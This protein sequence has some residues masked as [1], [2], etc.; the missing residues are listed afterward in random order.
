MPPKAKTSRDTILK[1]ALDLTREQGEGAL[2]ARAIAD[3]IGCSTQPIF[4]NYASMAELRSDVTRAAI[5]CYHNMVE[6]EMRDHP[7][8]PYK[9]SGLAYI[10][11]AKEERELFKLLF[12]RERTPA[13]YIDD[14]KSFTDRIVTLVS[15]KTGFTPEE[16][17]RLHLELW[18]FVHGIASMI[19]TAYLDWDWDNISQMLSDAYL[20][21][22][23]HHKEKHAASESETAE[24]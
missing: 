21:L 10:R 4:S 11:F 2:N 18:I 22:V 23:Q 3:R 24:N 16:A 1:A 7:A 14:D 12:M 9:A 6:T 19:A 17:Y 5:A 15:E 20:S 13:Q 8:L